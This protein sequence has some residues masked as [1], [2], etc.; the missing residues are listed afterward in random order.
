VVAQ[1]H[2]VVALLRSLS[3]SLFLCSVAKRYLRRLQC[4]ELFYGLF[5]ATISFL[6]GSG[7]YTITET[8]AT[9]TPPSRT[10]PRRLVPANNTHRIHA[11]ARCRVALLADAVARPAN[12][13][14]CTA[15]ADGLRCACVDGGARGL[16]ACGVLVDDGWTMGG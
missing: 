9:H 5:L 2:V 8:K 16:T 14:R 12:R 15:L 7:Y 10:P 11:C 3:L 6:E 1:T 13:V 4:F